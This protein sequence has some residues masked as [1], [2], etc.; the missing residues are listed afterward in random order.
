M[1]SAGAEIYTLWGVSLVP[2][3]PPVWPGSGLETIEAAGGTT[4]PGL[5]Q[6]G[7]AALP[8]GA[9]KDRLS[10][11]PRFLRG[12][13]SSKLAPV[14]TPELLAQHAGILAELRHRG[15]VRTGNAPLGD[16][17]EF[18]A[19]QV[20]GG[21]LAA[22]SSKSF[23]IKA[24]DGRLIQV[25]ARVVDPSTSRSAV[26]SAFRSFDFDAATF[27]VFDATTYQLEWAREV[28]PIEIETAARRSSHIN[29]HLLRI[30]LAEHL[31]FD[32]TD[33]FREVLDAS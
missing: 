4:N 18:V 2:R 23:D 29:A 13:E 25:K 26:F 3:R 24:A 17:A 32:V 28:T 22:N 8:R 12:L 11:G 7:P 14:T 10:A 19:H 27:M 31:G 30:S 6:T 20:Y 1:R 9:T 21:A 16:Y 5:D 33:R 15:V